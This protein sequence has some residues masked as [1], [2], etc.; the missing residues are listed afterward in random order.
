MPK[1]LIRLVIV[2][3]QQMLAETLAAWVARQPDFEL[4]G[5]AHDG[6][7]GWNLCLRAR[8]AVMV[9]DIELPKLDGLELAR[10]LLRQERPARVVAMSGLVDPYTIWRVRQ[11]GVHGYVEKTNGT[12][13]LI[14]AIRVVAAGGIY[15]SDVFEQVKQE[16]LAQPA[17]FHKVLSEREQEVLQYVVTGWHDEDIGTQFGISAATVAVHRK[18]I[19]QKLELHNDRELVAYARQWGL[20]RPAHHLPMQPTRHSEEPVN[21]RKRA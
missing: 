7:E 11:S 19:R 15:F 17:A 10:R 12:A 14:E 9:V 4:V 20:N 16:W 21:Q 18:H 6:E 2:E 3:D 1:K 5:L 13:T 8:P